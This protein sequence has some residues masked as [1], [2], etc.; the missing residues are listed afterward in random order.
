LPVYLRERSVTVRLL[1]YLLSKLLPLALLCLFQCG[2]FLGIVTLML[3]FEGSFGER[4]LTLFLAG[5]AATAMGLA[6]SA[7]VDSNDKAI[8]AL[9]LLLIPQF[10]LSNAVVD[11]S[12]LSETVAQV[13]VIAYWGVD[14]M[15]ATLAPELLALRDAGGEALIARNGEWGQDLLWL[16]AQAAGLLA[17][18]LIGLKRAD[19][20]G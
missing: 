20:R 14:A 5:F 2:L 8:A 15:R 1:P 18:T 7:F 16:G 6:V 19:R 11:L 10:I 4:L 13:T 3:G 12:G 9:P 17:L